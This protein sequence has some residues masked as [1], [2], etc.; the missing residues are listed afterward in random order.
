MQQSPHYVLGKFQTDFAQK[1]LNAIATLH[2]NRIRVNQTWLEK[3]QADPTQNFSS[4]FQKKLFR[5][6]SKKPNQKFSR[7]NS[8]ARKKDP[9]SPHPHAVKHIPGN[10]FFLTFTPFQS[11]S[12]T[13]SVVPL[14]RNGASYVPGFRS[15]D[16]LFDRKLLED[17]TRQGVR[18]IHSRRRTRIYDGERPPA[19]GNSPT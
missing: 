13:G 19:R 10:P 6:F 16:P 8:P 9:E 4:D 3:F 7:K 17:F 1:N 11:G 2:E 5:I 18:M 15:S 14:F 12:D